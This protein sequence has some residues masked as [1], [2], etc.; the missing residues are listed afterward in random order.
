MWTMADERAAQGRATP[1]PQTEE[2]TSVER[3]GIV[4]WHLAHGEEM[5][6]CEV[7]QLTGLTWEG[8]YELLCR[9]SRVIPICQDEH[10]VWAHEM[11][12]FHKA[13]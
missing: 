7:A 13:V 5:R 1:E 10:G 4:S 9:L 2:Y 6:A 12:I 3:Y 8:A 11:V